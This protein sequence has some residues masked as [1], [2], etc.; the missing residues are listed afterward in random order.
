MRWLSWMILRLLALF[1]AEPYEGLSD[2][3]CWRIVKKQTHFLCPYTREPS[4][5]KFWFGEGL[6][7]GLAAS[8]QEQLRGRMRSGKWRDWCRCSVQK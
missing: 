8:A 6:H 4:P 2:A 7:R 1:S 5:L 3:H